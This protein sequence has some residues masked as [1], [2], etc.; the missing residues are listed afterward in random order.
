MPNKKYEIIADS[1]TLPNNNIVRK[2]EVIDAMHFQSALIAKHIA[3]GHI[4]PVK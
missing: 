4:K 1:I 3:D 2:G